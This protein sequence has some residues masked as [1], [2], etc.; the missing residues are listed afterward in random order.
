LTEH[1]KSGPQEVDMLEWM[2]RTAL[3]YIGQAGLG[4]SF[5]SFSKESTNEYSRAIKDFLFVL[6]F[7]SQSWVI[8]LSDWQ[9]VSIPTGHLT[10]I[11]PILRQTW[12]S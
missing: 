2:S 6:S 9:S 11:H 7:F 3:E 12:S 4:Y 10:P 1:V 8:T 5:E